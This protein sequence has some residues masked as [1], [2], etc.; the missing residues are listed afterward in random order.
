VSFNA[1]D[2]GSDP[3]SNRITPGPKF[4]SQLGELAEEMVAVGLGVHEGT[5]VVR[6]DIHIT[7]MIREKGEL[8]LV[9]IDLDT[10]K[11]CEFLVSKLAWVE[12]DGMLEDDED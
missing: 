12:Y 11:K 5:R 7:L 2:D 6:H 9:G 1:A 3:L 10:D 8:I 4:E